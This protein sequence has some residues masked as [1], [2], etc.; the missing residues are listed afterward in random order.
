MV[1]LA[2]ANFYCCRDCTLL[3]S[4]HFTGFMKDSELKHPKNLRKIW[5]YGTVIDLKNGAVK[6]I[7]VLVNK[8]N[9]IGAS[10]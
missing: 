4:S 7:P 10:S 1:T 2:I 5:L 6:A 3:P 8:L 9:A